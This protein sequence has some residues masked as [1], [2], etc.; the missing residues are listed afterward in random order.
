MIRN[1]MLGIDNRI[2]ATSAN[3]NIGPE[4]IQFD[5]QSDFDFC[6][7]ND[8]KIV[9]GLLVYDPVVEPQPDATLAERNRADID[10]LA[11]IGGVEL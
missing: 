8:Y 7:Q 2:V 6:T 11:M 1:V 9:D 4:Q 10:Y 5:F 3:Y